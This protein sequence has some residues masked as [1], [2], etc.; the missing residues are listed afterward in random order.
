MSLHRF[1][2]GER[3]RA[4]VDIIY[5]TPRNAPE[6]RAGTRGVVASAALGGFLP[7]V[8]WDGYEPALATSF[9]SLE[10]LEDD[11]ETRA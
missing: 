6:I 2:K 1:S 5:G 7:H 11:Q 10:L 8:K 3:V 4:L 9:D